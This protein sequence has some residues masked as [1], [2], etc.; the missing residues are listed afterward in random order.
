MWVLKDNIC[1]S[2][3]PRVG[4]NTV[5]AVVHDELTNEQAMAYPTRIA[6]IRDPSDRWVSYYSMAAAFEAQGTEF[7]HKGIFTSYEAFVDYALTHN[8]MHWRSQKESLSIDGVYIATE[9]HRFDEI[10]IH[11]PHAGFLPNL[12]SVKHLPVNNYRRDDINAYLKDDI[13]LF[14]SLG[15]AA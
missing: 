7:P 2:C 6:F 12:N 15:K 11:W 5:R 8:D 14:N 9:T 3:I 4:S 13:I 1:I 10:R